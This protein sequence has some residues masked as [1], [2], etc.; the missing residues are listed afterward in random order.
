MLESI[1]QTKCMALECIALQMAIDMKDL[2][3]KEHGKDSEC[4][5]SEMGK[6][7]LGTGRM[8]FLKYHHQFLNIVVKYLMQFR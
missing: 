3:M 7:D 4:I 1:L 6:H 2:G 8:A 5:L